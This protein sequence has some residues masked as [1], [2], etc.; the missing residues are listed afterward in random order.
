MLA[1]GA[2]RRTQHQAEL[3]GQAHSLH[4]RRGRGAHRVDQAG[5]GSQPRQRERQVRDRTSRRR[6]RHHSARMSQ[7]ESG[8]HVR[9][10]I[11]E[12]EARR[13]Q[14]TRIWQSQQGKAAHF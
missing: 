13:H 3:G 11:A 8:E 4:A 9:A 14:T 5:R 10:E 2:K 7:R 1:D 6:A 12:L